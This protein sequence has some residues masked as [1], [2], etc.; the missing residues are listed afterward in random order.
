MYDSFKHGLVVSKYWLSD[1]LER[2]LNFKYNNQYHVYVLGA[3]H[4]LLP[5]IMIT[6]KPDA[7]RAFYCYDIDESCKAQAE[8]LCDTWRFEE[9][10]VNHY[11]QNANDIVYTTKNNIVIN[12]S[13]D[14]FS[15]DLWFHK[16]NKGDLVCVQC[17]DYNANDWETTNIVNSI[18]ELKNRFKFSKYLYEGIKHID[19][20][21]V[22]AALHYKRFMIIG[23]K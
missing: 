22:G 6:R 11:T 18:D 23:Y 15:N 4:G 2:C 5:F 3:W 7:Y 14:Q 19:Y 10:K 16:V 9:P 20:R 1:E 17:T 12:C 13:V 8:Q 21:N